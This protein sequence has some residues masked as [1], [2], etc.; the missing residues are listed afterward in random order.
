[1]SQLISVRSNQSLEVSYEHEKLIPLTEIIILT[2]KPK[3]S[4]GKDDR[5][6]RGNK[7]TETRFKCNS[8]SLVALIDQLQLAKVVAE[9]YEKIAENVIVGKPVAGTPVNSKSKSKAKAK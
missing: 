5:I 2:E 1:M 3:Y 4:F 8:A 9:Q 6:L 7:I